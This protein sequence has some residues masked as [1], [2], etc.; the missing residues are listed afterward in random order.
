MNNDER[1][2]LLANLAHCKA[3]AENAYDAMY[4]AHS[5]R[6]AND[7]YR[8]AKEFFWSAIGQAEELELPEEAEALRKRLEHVQAV[9]RGQFVQ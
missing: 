2:T 7:C 4:E 3:E 9:F 8:E 6:D 1:Q 5:F